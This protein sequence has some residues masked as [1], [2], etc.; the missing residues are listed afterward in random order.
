MITWRWNDSSVRRAAQGPAPAT[1]IVEPGVQFADALE[2][3]HGRGLVD[4]DIKPENVLVRRSCTV[5]VA[6]NTQVAKGRMPS[7]RLP[8]RRMVASVKG[9]SA[10]RWTDHSHD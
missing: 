10:Q 1:I 3:A 9:R 8:T 5:S 4:R 6:A 7:F 2:A